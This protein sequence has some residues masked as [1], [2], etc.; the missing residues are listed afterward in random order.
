MTDPFVMGRFGGLRKTATDHAVISTGATTA[1][2]RASARQTFSSAPATR[3]FSDQQLEMPFS[4]GVGR[5][6][7]ETAKLA[8]NAPYSGTRV[9]I[10]VP[11]LSDKLTRSLITSG[12]VCGITPSSIRL[13]SGQPIRVLAFDAPDGSAAASPNEVSSFSKGSD[14]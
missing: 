11:S 6:T 3:S 1:A 8:S 10:S 2:A 7:G 9:R 12:L 13:L 4:S 14:Q 5:S